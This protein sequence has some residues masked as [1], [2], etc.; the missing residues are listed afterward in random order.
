MW[1]IWTM[2]STLKEVSK[3]VQI[4]AVLFSQTFT[5]QVSLLMRISV[6]G[7]PL[8]HS[9]GWGHTGTE[10]PAQLAFPLT[11]LIRQS[12]FWRS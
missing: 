11:E 9:S 8:N 6:Y 4:M 3:T 2:V 10:L 1:S 12:R 5:K 7:S